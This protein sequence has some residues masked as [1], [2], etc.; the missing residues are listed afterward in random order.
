M[1]ICSF[2]LSMD[3]SPIIDLNS[4]VEEDKG[5]MSGEDSYQLACLLSRSLEELQQA[6]LV[7]FRHRVPRSIE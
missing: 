6:Y 7:L 1:K 5:S 4:P 2:L 3:G